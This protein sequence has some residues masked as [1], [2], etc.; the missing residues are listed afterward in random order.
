[1][2]ISDLALVEAWKEVLLL[3]K[4]APGEQVSLLV[5]DD[6]NPQLVS[7]ARIAVGQLGGV[8]TILTLPPLNGDVALSRD[9][10]GYVG[11]T[12][13]KGNRPALEAMKHSDLVIDTMM[14][15]F[16][17]EQ[18]EILKTG[19][20][21]LLACE[22]PE[23]MLRM[24]PTPE[25]ARRASAGA[26]RLGQAKVMTVTSKAGTDFRCEL[27]QYPVLKQQG[28]V[29][30]KG[31]WDHWPSC[32]VATWPNEGSCEGTIVID[33]GDIL[34]PF[35]R[36]A[37]EPIRITIE[38]GWIRRIEGGFEAEYLR[39]YMDSFN[40]PDAYAMAHVGWGLHR[41]A[42]WTQLGLYDRESGL[43]MDARS[44]WGNFLWSSGPN[45][46]AGGN[47]D[48]PCHMDIPLRAHSL[49]LDGEPMTLDGKVIPPDQA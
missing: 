14:L 41:K 36:Y 43:S 10:S 1:M 26:A 18:E 38:G 45:T 11:H 44:F 8:L 46:E 47:R 9:K 33:T 40:D 20:R 34:L 27:G 28:F 6:S 42:H 49:F 3:S 22:P 13:L 31:G 35:K 19:A 17:P 15:L 12:A 24:K 32:F 7:T 23:V 5:S 37:R 29:D 4:L 21:M 48:T 2:A 25:D 39:T 16:S 30:R